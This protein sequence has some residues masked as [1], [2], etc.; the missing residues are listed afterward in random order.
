MKRRKIWIGILLLVALCLSLCACSPAPQSGGAQSSGTQGGTSRPKQSSE[1]VKMAEEAQ[2]NVVQRLAST[3]VKAPEG[4]H[5]NWIGGLVLLDGRLYFRTESMERSRIFSTDLEGGDR[6]ELGAYDGTRIQGFAASGHGTFYV[7]N[8]VFDEGARRFVY[9]LQEIDR[10]GAALRREPLDGAIREDFMPFWVAAREDELFLLGDGVLAALRVGERLEELFTLSVD[11]AALMTVLPDGRLLLGERDGGQYALR[12]LDTESGAETG[13]C[14]FDRGSLSLLCG[15]E[16]WDVYL[17]D[18][19]SAYGFDLATGRLEK[20]FEWLSVGIIGRALLEA[21]EGG[22]FAADG[23]SRLFR[24]RQVDAEVGE[25]GEP[26]TMTLVVLDR[27]FLPPSLEEAILDWDREHPEC[28]IV[29]RDFYRGEHSNDWQK[30]ERATEEARKAMALAVIT[31]EIR[32][33]L[34]DLSSLNAAALA[35]G[36]HLEDLYPYLDA[37]PELSRESFY[38]NVLQAQEIRGG[39]YEVVTNYSLL[40][41]LGYASELGGARSWDELLPLAESTPRCRRLIGAEAR[42]RMELLELLTAASGKKLVDWDSG[43]CRF[44]TP[45]F[46]SLLTACAQLPAQGADPAGYYE[47]QPSPADGDGLLSV[48]EISELWLGAA[49]SRDYGEGGC[50]VAGLP[51]LGS[52]LMPYSALGCSALGMA[53]DSQHKEA[54]WSFLRRFYLD[55]PTYAFGAMQGDLEDAI[56]KELR[57]REEEG[58]TDRWPNAEADMRLFADAFAGATV[59]YREDEAVWQIVQAEA[60]RYFAGQI[61]AEECARAVQSR[62]QI[63]LA[64]QCG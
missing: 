5:I 36:G 20:Q 24:M 56:R 4:E 39:L 46:R 15:G 60:E 14:H 44:D 35:V 18:G 31:G 55:A 63:Y 3:E 57:Q 30:E 19:T 59:L 9:S 45:Y 32:P 40:T 25:S 2:K 43:E 16:R 7:L 33:D 1:P 37:D 42:S 38:P 64:E 26:E 11:P 50:A 49:W 53:A 51:E 52:V 48:E 22:F 6:Q 58:L 13:V 41:A 17:S 34:F 61:S 28:A 27:L 62:A 47:S 10:S 23:N 21:P 8:S 29:V 54:C 12:V